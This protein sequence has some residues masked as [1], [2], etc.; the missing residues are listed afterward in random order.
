LQSSHFVVPFPWQAGQSFMMW[1]GHSDGL[2]GCR[3]RRLAQFER[4]DFGETERVCGFVN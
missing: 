3:S 1:S 2:G 4:I